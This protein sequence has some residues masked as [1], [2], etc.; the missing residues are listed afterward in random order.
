MTP[1]T[2]QSP[3]SIYCPLIEDISPVIFDL[4]VMV[5]SLIRPIPRTDNLKFTPKLNWLWA[6]KWETVRYLQAKGAFHRRF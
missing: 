2:R 6:E 3:L 1:K 4:Q 5:H